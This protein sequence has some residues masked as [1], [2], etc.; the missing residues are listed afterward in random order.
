MNVCMHVGG[1]GGGMCVYDI[2]SEFRSIQLV[3]RKPV[4]LYLHPHPN[5]PQ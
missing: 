4:H 2:K 1:G 3:Y 5:T